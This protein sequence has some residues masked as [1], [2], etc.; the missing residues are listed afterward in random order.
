[1]A[2][3]DLAVACGALAAAAGGCSGGDEDGA[4]GAGG[5]T[6]DCKP[7]AD[8]CYVG[9]PSGPGNECLAKADHSAS[10]K[11][12]LR[13][14]QHQVAKPATLAKPYVQ[15]V[16]ITKKSALAQPECNQYGLAQFNLLLEIDSAA[17]KLTLGG[18]VP[19]LLIGD[20]KDGTCW[21]DFVDPTSQ[22]EVKPITVDY[23]EAAGGS[24]EAK[25][26]DFV[27]P[28]YL[29]D[30]TNLDS[31]VLVPL[32]QMTVTAKLSPDKNC[33]GRYAHDDATRLDE[34][35]AAAEDQFAWE[36]GGRYEGYITVEEA[37]DVMVVSLGQTLCVVLSGDPAK[38]KGTAKSC[39]TSQAYLQEG[40]PKGDWCKATNSA[41]GCEDAWYLS[42][43]IAAAAIQINGSWD[44]ATSSCQ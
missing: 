26:A 39:K 40:L 41:G 36:N 5:G 3:K 4:G 17:K 2:W 28:I 31:Y 9:G 34:S 33:I 35:C 43:D 32:H 29:E 6:R 14:T 30:K 10:D 20:P 37:D 23:T 11:T 27:M 19:Q 18:G 24:L 12:Q 8:V 25:I 21:A 22:L 42:I 15:D 16:V 7:T 13:I 38:W 44:D 1:M